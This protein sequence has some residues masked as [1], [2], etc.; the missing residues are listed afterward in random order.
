VKL[1]LKGY[2]VAA[3]NPGLFALAQALGGFFSRVYSP[4]SAYM[5]IPAFTGWGY[6]KDFPRLSTH[7]FHTR[8]KAVRQVVGKEPPPA[9]K[10]AKEPPPTLLPTSSRVDRFNSEFT[11]LGGHIHRVA[12]KD[13]T[14]RLAEFL[15]ARG[16]DRV[17][18][19]ETGEKY[20]SGAVL[21]RKP[22][23]TV[24]LGVTGTLCGIAE[25]GSLVI[26]GGA[27]RPLTASL[28]P[29]T[30]VA[31]LKA[32]QILPTVA[33]ALRRPEVLKASAG[34]IITG[35]SRTADIEMALTIGVHGPGE[36][37]VFLVED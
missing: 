17:L 11:A 15:K 32:F 3:R 19:D 37:H 14:V 35:P 25:T 18:V 4:R 1:G 24:R 2:R 27:G 21:V 29:E 28:L 34:A 26:V 23:P 8:W 9:S 33:E 7:T 13:L 36:V 5:R 12:E 20:V 6:S 16:V 31:I 10:P 30:Y 22:D